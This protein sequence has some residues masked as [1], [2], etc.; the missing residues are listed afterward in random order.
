MLLRG[1]WVHEFAELESLSR[2]EVTTM[3]AF[4]VRQVDRVRDPYKRIVRDV[5][6]RCVF[7]GTTN[8]GGYLRDSTGNRRFWPLTLMSRVDVPSIVRDR[9]QLWAEASSLEAGGASD[10][11]PGSLW[12]VAAD[13]QADEAT[14]DRGRTRSCAA[15]R[16]T[17][18]QCSCTISRGQLRVN[19]PV[20][21]DSCSV[22]SVH[23]SRIAVPCCEDHIKTREDQ[24]WR[25]LQVSNLRPA[26]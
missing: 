15:T 18:R 20:L 16:R 5:P 12:P 21:V 4:V 24:R 23:R 9:E 13:R 6:R 3:K 22:A 1:I 17:K 14:K 7:V 19:G 10:V 25:P 8:E 26:V 2:S 11:L